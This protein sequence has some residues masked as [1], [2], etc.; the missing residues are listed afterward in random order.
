[1]NAIYNEIGKGY[2]TTRRAD[3]EILNIL[4]SLMT[5]REN[6]LYLDVGC[7]TGNY[8]HELSKIC[9][10]WRAFDQSAL[11]IEKA[12]EKNSNVEWSV[13]DVISTSYTSESFNS[14]LCTL[15]IH[16]FQNLSAAFREISRIL[17]PKGKFVIFTSTPEQMELYW[18]NHYFPRMLKCSIK[19]MP[20]ISKI[21]G[22]LRNASLKLVKNMPFTVS[23]E[24]K[25]LFL[26]SGKQR[27]EM[28]LS[29]SVRAGISS[30]RNFC[31]STELKSGSSLLATDIESGE[32]DNVIK[33]YGESKEGDYCF[34]VAQK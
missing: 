34:L 19:Q 18:L 24:L 2:D 21:E 15:A 3:P 14:I 7:G 9:G 12:K 4:A 25:D 22:A 16:H 10:E 5:L 11:M 32:I 1:M 17:A 13:F 29:E 8:T 23:N 31:P 27:P 6:G 30:F 33:K 28:Y 20:T 26:Y